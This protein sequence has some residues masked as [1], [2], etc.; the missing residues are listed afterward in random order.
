M[1][2][3]RKIINQM[4]LR[5]LKKEISFYNENN[6]ITSIQKTKFEEPVL[7]LAKKE[8]TDVFADIHLRSVHWG[9]MHR[10]SILLNFSEDVMKIS[11]VR[12]LASK[13]RSGKHSRGYGALLMEYA[14]EE[15]KRRGIKSVIGDM[16]ETEPGQRERQ[17]S[18]YTKFGFTIDSDNKIY[19][20]M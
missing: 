6:W 18:Y 4:K 16:V 5:K 8:F 15:A 1:V 13:P 10:S 3:F 7:I 20:K 14:L 19:K 12:V 2:F 17:I 11:D 9:K